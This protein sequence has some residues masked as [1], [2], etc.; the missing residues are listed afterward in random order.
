MNEDK[1]VK[2]AYEDDGDYE[3]ESSA[4][5]RGVKG[6]R[7]ARTKERPGDWRK[8]GLGLPFRPPSHRRPRQSPR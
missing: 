7:G 6:K 5:K 2:E 4:A 1:E 8:S 3:A